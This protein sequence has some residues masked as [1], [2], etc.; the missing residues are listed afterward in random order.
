MALALIEV[1][2]GVPVAAPVGEPTALAGANGHA[3]GGVN[4]IGSNG[5][6]NGGTGSGTN[7]IGFLPNCCSQ[8]W[9]SSL[10]FT[11][12]VLR[13]DPVGLVLARNPLV[14]CRPRAR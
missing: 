14:E 7:G 6:A 4:G 12:S 8:D 13:P 5:G 1:P 11:R 3:N 9:E 2:M 10:V